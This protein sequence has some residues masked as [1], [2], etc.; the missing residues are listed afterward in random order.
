MGSRQRSNIEQDALGA[1][2]QG[3]ALCKLH[4]TPEYHE[5]EC[6]HAEF[7]YLG[8]SICTE[9]EHGEYDEAEAIFETQYGQAMMRIIDALTS[10]NQLQ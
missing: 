2:I 8:A 3:A 5:L 4:S 1:W 10:I 7:R 9:L 6:A